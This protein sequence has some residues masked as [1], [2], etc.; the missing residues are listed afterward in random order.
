M[1]GK[2][3]RIIGL[4]L[5]RSAAILLVMLGH[6]LVFI[7]NATAR[8]IFS[9]D[10][11]GV[12]VF[13]V[14]SGFLIGKILLKSF[15]GNPGTKE[16]VRFWAFRWAKTLPSYYVVL[17]GL[18]LY[19]WLTKQDTGSF[20]WEYFV[21][22]HNFTTSDLTFFRESWSLSIEE[23]FYFSFPLLFLVFLRLRKSA[24]TILPVIILLYFSFS[25]FLRVYAYE[26]TAKTLNEEDL[27]QIVLYRFDAISIGI[28]LSWIQHYFSA[29]WQKRNVVLLLTGLTAILFLEL[30]YKLQWITIY[31]PVKL[32]IEAISIACTIP[33]FSGKMTFKSSFFNRALVYIST[34]SYALYLLNLTFIQIIFLPVLFKYLP[35]TGIYAGARFLCY[36]L[37]SFL[38]AEILYRCVEKPVITFRNRYK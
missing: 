3:R 25:F 23:W 19:Y 29:A 18:L 30:N 37:F 7:P 24:F 16:L 14:L 12:T 4:D 35:L 20:S 22:T 17:S 28:L 13:F 1:T 6:S 34:R 2:G 26:S 5:V 15:A 11:D 8:G 32:S 31:P 38:F 27:Q 21:F 33:Y 36:W 9:P 10:L